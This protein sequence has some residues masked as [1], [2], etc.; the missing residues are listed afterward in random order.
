MHSVFLEFIILQL[1]IHSLIMGQVIYTLIMLH[2]KKELRAELKRSFVGEG[3][4]SGNYF[5][6]SLFRK[7]KNS[8]DIK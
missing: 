4:L 5:L 7:T 3:K 8:I 2:C 6:E 1:G